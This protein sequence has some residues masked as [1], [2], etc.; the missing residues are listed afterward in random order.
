MEYI[1]EILKK[2]QKTDYRISY[3]EEEQ[4]ERNGELKYREI[5]KSPQTIQVSI[6]QKK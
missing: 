6:R 5:A 1:R 2:S 3:R 4:I